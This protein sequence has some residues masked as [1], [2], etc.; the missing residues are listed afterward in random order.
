MMKNS[1]RSK[2]G[3]IIKYDLVC[4]FIYNRVKYIICLLF[5]LLNCALFSTYSSWVQSA[6]GTSGRTLIDC[7]IYFFKGTKVIRLETDALNIPVIFLGL[8]IIIASMVGYYPFDDIYGYGKQVFI[9]V[10][11]KNKWLF[12]KCIWVF[13]TVI[14]TYVVIYVTI[15]LYCAIAG[16]KI[17]ITYTPELFQQLDNIYIGFIPLSDVM[18]YLFVTP[19]VYSLVVSLVQ[20]MVSLIAGPIISFLAVMIYHILGILICHQGLF[21]NYSMMY[22]DMNVTSINIQPTEGIV[23]MLGVMVLSIIAGVIVIDKK[24]IFEK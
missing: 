10:D 21:A 16:V 6:D 14:T 13:A 9:R 18:L 17:D 3:K 24:E 5:I 11:K 4:G 23:Y 20:V 2:F 15:L 8:Q 22:R 19:L 7:L 12:S 1:K